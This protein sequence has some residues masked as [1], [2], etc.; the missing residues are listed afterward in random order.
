M[1]D[2]ITSESLKSLATPSVGP[3]LPAGG[4]VAALAL[5]QAAALLARTGDGA[6]GGWMHG[7]RLAEQ[8]A[9]AVRT[10]G[11]ESWRP[12]ADVITAAASLP[13]VAELRLSE[14]SGVALL[15]V[16]A[17]AEVMRSAAVIARVAIESRTG[18]VPVPE[19]DGLVTRAE[20]ITEA[21]RSG[22]SNQLVG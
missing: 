7:L 13:A 3:A 8:D 16:A 20:R 2:Q 18:S 19:V 12:S 14:V 9:F 5:A 4:T 10:S 6:C 17:A 11:L 15:D 22:L 1:R 21:V